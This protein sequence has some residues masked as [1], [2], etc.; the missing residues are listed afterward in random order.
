VGASYA[1]GRDRDWLYRQRPA[2]GTTFPTLS[3]GHYSG[4]TRELGLPPKQQNVPLYPP[5]IARGHREIFIGGKDEPERCASLDS[6]FCSN[7]ARQRYCKVAY[8]KGSLY[9]ISPKETRTKAKLRWNHLRG[10]QLHTVDYF[11]VLWDEEFQEPVLRST[12]ANVHTVDVTLGRHTVTTSS[13]FGDL[14][15][16]CPNVHTLYVETRGTDLGSSV[17]DS[18]FGATKAIRQVTTLTVKQTP[19]LSAQMAKALGN[20][21]SLQHLAWVERNFA[22][23]EGVAIPSL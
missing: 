6:A 18:L 11:L 13:L 16:W 15:K 4:A 23:P 17:D 3:T 2:Q 22:V 14:A 8:D 12:G 21:A 1:R 5:S 19:S 9:V 10:L 7:H 20:C